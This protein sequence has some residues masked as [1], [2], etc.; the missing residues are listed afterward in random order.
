[1]FTF[2]CSGIHP[3]SCDQCTF[4]C[5][6]RYQLKSHMRTHTKEKPYKCTMCSYAAAW[7]MQLK[8]HTKAHSRSTALACRECGVVLKNRHTLHPREEGTC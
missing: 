7:N 2:F 4:T 3:Y 6:Q 5:V 1:M 8:E